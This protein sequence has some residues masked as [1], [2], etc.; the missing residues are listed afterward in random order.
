MA[1]I[2]SI[3]VGRAIQAQINQ[4]NLPQREERAA[5]VQTTRQVR[6]AKKQELANEK[7]A[8]AIQRRRQTVDDARRAQLADQALYAAQRKS[9]NIQDSDRQYALLQADITEETLRARALENESGPLPPLP[10]RELTS[11]VL[12]PADIE[13]RDSLNS[14]SESNLPRGSLVDIYA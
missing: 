10:P 6:S 11:T 8:Q 7:L 3:G 12:T 1:E 9:Q 4:R 5:P 13:A 2:A 14:V